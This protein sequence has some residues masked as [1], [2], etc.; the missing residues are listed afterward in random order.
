MTR[1]A[2]LRQIAEDHEQFRDG[3]PRDFE[4]YILDK[5]GI[6]LKAEYAGHIIRNPFGKASGQ[7]SLNTHQIE[8]DAEA[9]LGFAVLKTLIAE[10][11]SG[12]QSMSAWA[13]P[14]ARMKVERIVRN[15]GC[16]TRNC[17]LTKIS[18]RSNRTYLY[19]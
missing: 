4:E 11:E 3:L 12:T 17:L 10:S 15:D 1:E 5:Y 13:I 9:G 19:K 7:L 8:H 2:L 6:S 14:E 16:V 18:I